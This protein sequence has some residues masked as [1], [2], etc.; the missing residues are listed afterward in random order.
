M[1]LEK[2]LVLNKYF[3]NLFGA[4]DFN[5]L[6]SKLSSYEGDYDSHGR[7]YYID[8]LIGLNPNLE[9]KLLKYDEAIKEYVEKL[10]VNRKNLSFKLKYFQYLAVLFTEMFLDEYFNDKTRF[11]HSLNDFLETFNAENGTQI[12]PFE[13]KD[14]RKLAFWMATGSGKTLIMHINYWQM[15]KYSKNAWD[16]IIL[17]TPNEGLSKQHYDEMKLSGVP[18]KLYDGNIHTLET[19]K[20]EVLIIDIHKLT[21][22]KTGEGISVDVSTF[23]GKNLVFIDEGHKGAGNVSETGWK[24]LRESV[25]KDGFIFE[26]SATFGQIIEFT[27]RGKVKVECLDLYNEYTKSIIFDYS[28]KYFYTDGYGKDF[29]V[30]NIPTGNNEYTEEQQELLLK[31]GLLA[32]YEQL[33]IFKEHKDELKEYNIEKPLWIF[34][35]SKVSGTELNSD[36]MKVVKFLKRILEDR[37]YLKDNIEKILNGESGL[38]DDEG[39]D[40]FRDKFPYVRRKRAEGKTIDDIIDEIYE[41]VFHGSGNLKIYE[42]KNADGEIGLKTTTGEKYFGVINIGDVP[43]LKKLITTLPIQVEEDHLSPSLFFGIDSENS[44]INILIGAR[45]F[46]EGW[47][48]W[49]VSCMGLINMGRTEGPQIIQLFGRGVRLK[50]KGFS[51]KREENP[52]IKIK[53]LQTILIFGLNADYVQTFLDKIGKEEVPYDEIEISI[54]FNRENLWN[55]K[56][57]TIQVKDEFDFLKHPV[58]LEK[59]DDLIGNIKLDLRPK[60]TVAHGLEISTLTTA[61]ESPVTIPSEYFGIINWDWI[62]SEIINYKIAKSMFNLIINKETIKDIITAQRYKIYMNDTTGIKI[63]NVNNYPTLKIVTFEG[64]NKLHEI[65]LMTLKEYI[66]KF[67]RKAENTMSMDYLEVQKLSRDKHR[68]MFPED[69]KIILKIPRNLINDIEE[70]KRQLET[71]N[72]CSIP[73]E[74]ESSNT[75]V[76]HFDKHLYTPLIVYKQGRQEITSIPVKLNEGETR[77]VTDLKTYLQNND[78]RADVFLLRN[79]SRRGVGFFISSGFY[80]DFILWINMENSQYITFIDPKGIRNL[81]NFND[82]KI[83]FCSSIIKE[84]ENKVQSDLKSKKETTE[85]NLNAFI[86]SVSPYESI[87]RVFGNGNHNKEEFE[88]HNI[89]FQDGEYI[90][91]LFEKILSK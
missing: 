60:I 31:A 52:D 32:F 49:R 57:Y 80:P 63:L 62:Y 19:R 65:I 76:I 26:Y 68:S 55:D 34:V 72:L 36:I 20:E 69:N 90:K 61:V 5:D 2:H 7:S 88:E 4:N 75:F 45:K 18:C 46:I 77:F 67:Y 73:N 64:V 48:S 37:Q 28:Y 33:A 50:G 56:L 16:K 21:L 51:L 41:N 89:I 17:I 86:I 82:D 35:G 29:Y 25:A 27:R 22:E 10:K 15:L 30:Y 40:L 12:T 87:K 9:E 8:A 44:Y 42:I 78:I 85:L 3:L 59:D 71:Y 24:T 1:L 66:N 70:I 14:L 91:L 47:N 81:G 39:N 83:Q 58:T 43:S 53:T 74:W 11:L 79:L 38:L 13:E 23:D 54:K 6:R 84:I